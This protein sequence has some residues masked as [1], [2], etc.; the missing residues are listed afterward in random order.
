MDDSEKMEAAP[1]PVAPGPVPG[2][3]VP[4]DSVLNLRDLGGWP[5]G[6]GGHVRRRQVYRSGALDQLS[7][8]D[9]DAFRGLG[10]RTVYDLRTPVERE[11]WPDRVPDGAVS[12]A[13][14]VF[15]GTADP[16]T[17]Q[18]RAAGDAAAA[19]ALL[20]GADGA[21]VFASGYRALV[22][23]PS[24]REAYRRLFAGLAVADRRP[25]LVHCAVGKDRTGWAAAALLLFLGVPDELVLEEFLTSNRDLFPAGQAG[26]GGFRVPGGDPERPAPLVVLRP[27]FL[28][29]AVAEM[30]GRYGTA[31]GYFA[32]GL[33]LSEETRAALRAALVEPR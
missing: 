21:A 14:D 17:T 27:E 12:L 18:V 1:E 32:A 11:T 9:E 8:G 2:A 15:A 31:D 23:L 33:G 5:T 20:G 13:L 10:I 4:I 3:R 24:A 22:A 19:A 29:A 30:M 6:D 26:A 28:E 25:A 7:A 16:V